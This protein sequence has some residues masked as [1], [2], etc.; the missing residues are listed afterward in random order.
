MNN[1]IDFDAFLPK[2]EEY[3]S[4]GLSAGM[5][6]RD[7]QMCIEAVV[8]AALGLPHGDNPN[9]VAP[10]VR[11]YKI[12]L[13][14]SAWSSEMVRAAG[15]HD[16]G[17]AQVGSA[18]IVDDIRFTQRMAEETIRQIIPTLF[19]ELYPSNAYALAAA[20]R[21]EQEGTVGAA[22]RA[23]WTVRAAA[24]EAAR[25]AA[26]AA[27]TAMAAAWAAGSEPDK[28]L[29]LSANIA[30][31]VLRELGSPGCAYVGRRP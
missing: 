24:A 11:A 26:W 29:L 25:A 5:G 30:L 23:A 19:R 15:L 8:C 3:I 28:Y 2:Y 31:D 22:A 10:A 16:L 1:T 13:N 18:G 17:I 21:C 12:I 20:E 9:C 6:D 14:D 27:R 4:R 7:G